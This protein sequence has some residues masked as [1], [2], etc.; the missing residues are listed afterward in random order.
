[1]GD[2]NWYRLAF[3]AQILFYRGA[4][5]GWILR[6]SS[7]EVLAR[8]ISLPVLLVELGYSDWVLAMYHRSSDRA[9]AKGRQSGRPVTCDELAI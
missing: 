3:G 5:V 6:R 7:E 2:V 1:M 8:E 4:A 9:L